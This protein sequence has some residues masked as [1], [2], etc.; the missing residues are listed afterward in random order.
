MCKHEFVGRECNFFCRR[1][2]V[3]VE[4]IRFSLLHAFWKASGRGTY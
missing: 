2:G 4:I 3:A 1:E